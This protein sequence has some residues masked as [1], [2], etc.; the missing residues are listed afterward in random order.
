MTSA[1]C[2]E[3]LKQKIGALEDHTKYKRLYNYSQ[4]FFYWND[5]VVLNEDVSV[6]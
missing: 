1:K 6:L 4:L 5:E 2:F 3:C